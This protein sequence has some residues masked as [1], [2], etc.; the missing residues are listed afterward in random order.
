[1][2]LNKPTIGLCKLDEYTSLSN[3]P[4]KEKWGP[5]AMGLDKCEARNSDFVL[6]SI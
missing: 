4:P 6:F 5:T 1:M 3:I 2:G